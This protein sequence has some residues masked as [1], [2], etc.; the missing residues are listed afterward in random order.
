MSFNPIESNRGTFTTAPDGSSAHTS[1]RGQ[2]GHQ[3]R[4]GVYHGPDGSSASISGRGS[5]TINPNRVVAHA[6]GCGSVVTATGSV[7]VGQVIRPGTYHPHQVPARPTTQRATIISQGGPQRRI[8]S[9][10]VAGS[11]PSQPRPMSSIRAVP[12]PGS[13]ASVVTGAYDPNRQST[14]ARNS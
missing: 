12:A 3:T 13:S 10:V 6:S 11:I 14:G 9:S 8:F 1:G 5:A 4:P 2:I 7:F